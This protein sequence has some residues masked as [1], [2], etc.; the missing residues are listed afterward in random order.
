MAEAE[1][2]AKENDRLFGC[3]GSKKTIVILTIQL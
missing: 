3:F 2:F 1:I